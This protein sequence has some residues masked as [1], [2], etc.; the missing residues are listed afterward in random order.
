MWKQKHQGKTGKGE[1]FEMFD[2]TF[3]TVS[4]NLIFL[5]SFKKGKCS[6][7]SFYLMYVLHVLGSIQCSN[8]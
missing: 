6:M 1:E 8:L 4:I 5:S 3:S 7:Q 2:Q